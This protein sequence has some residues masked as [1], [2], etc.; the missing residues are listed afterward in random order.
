MPII[1][2]AEALPGD[3]L[4][5]VIVGA[6]SAG[7]ALAGRLSQDPRARI[8]V[9]EAGGTNRTWSHRLPARGLRLIDDPEYDWRY[10][11]EPDPS[12]GGKVDL[13]YRGRG[14]GGSSAINGMVYVRGAPTDFDR[15]KA[16]GAD[17]W[18]WD[19]V[20]TVYRELERPAGKSWRGGTGRLRTRTVARP[21]R[22][23][24]AFLD[25]A[26]HAGLPRL[27][28]Y[29]DGDQ[30]GVALIELTQ[31]HGMRF[32]SADAFLRPA[33]AR[34]GNLWV[35]LDCSADRI[36][37]EGLRATGVE[38]RRGGKAETVKARNIIL[39][40]GAINSPKLLML[41]G[42]GDAAA[43]RKLG[44][45]PLV[46]NDQVGGNLREHPL[47]RLQ[48]SATVPTYNE[49]DKLGP[50]VGHV[51]QFLRYG[52]GPVSGVFEAI[53]FAR[54]SAAVATP[55][56]QLHFLPI[57]VRQDEQG[58]LTRSGGSGVTVY[59]NLSY[60][61]STGRIDLTSADPDAHPTIRYNLVGSDA[62][63]DAL[64][65][66]M[67]LVQS[68]MAQPPIAG[69]LRDETMPGFAVGGANREQARAYVRAGAE[70]AY[71]PIGTCAMGGGNRAVVTPR[72][73]VNGTAGL[74]IAD[75]SIMPDLI[76]GNTNA[77]CMMIGDRL[78]RWMLEDA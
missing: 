65:D 31:R 51:A 70:P 53:G 14:L 10:R 7:C 2:P 72:L 50:A 16:A 19:Q 47:V 17:G 4:D 11:T 46:D 77:T 1:T 76:S 28:D 23:T 24:D 68:I 22:T 48:Y 25:A 39:C 58:K 37:F 8:L 52:E 64:V 45:A 34:S 5:Y 13:Y 66:G 57:A 36:T 44:I 62:D 15:W 71:H 56:L 18:G 3:P 55:D 42:I 29:N 21:H 30:E 73:Q 26:A 63:V 12:R 32:S 75:A 38:I 33:L 49:A 6:G 40:A 27:A 59:V 20:S 54:S 60:P 78:G 69:L 41:S 74:W 35:A 61:T 9:L 67:A 43:L